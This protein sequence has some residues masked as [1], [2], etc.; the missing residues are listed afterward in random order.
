MN[1]DELDKRI[2][3]MLVE[4]ARS[5]YS[6][7]AREIGVAESTVLS[8][9]RKML[10]EGVIISFETRVNHKKLGYHIY[11]WIG[12]TT[13]PDKTIEAAEKIAEDDRT[14]EVHVTSGPHR[15]V[16]SG[17]FKD[18]EDYSDFLNKRIYPLTGLR[19][20]HESIVISTVKPSP[21]RKRRLV[22]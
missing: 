5:P 18:F 14:L 8:R 16:V 21:E 15:I 1:L 9:V 4:N 6:R 7:I 3:A 10:E 17:F 22:L 2:L 20:F 13:D 12:L 11:A 19:D